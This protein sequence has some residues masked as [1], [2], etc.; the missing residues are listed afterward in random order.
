MST[1]SPTHYAQYRD[2]FVFTVLGEHLDSLPLD[3]VGIVAHEGADPLSNLDT[4]NGR[5]ICD[6]ISRSDGE[7]VFEA[8]SKNTTDAS[9]CLGC[10][11]SGNRKSVYW[12]AS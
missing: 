3:I 7:I 1:V 11:A 8:R 12:Q 4:T 10:I 2:R 5:F 9:Y 6:P